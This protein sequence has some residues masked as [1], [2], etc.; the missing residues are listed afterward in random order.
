MNYRNQND[1]T[2]VLLTLAGEKEAFEALVVR[3]QNAVIAAAASVTHNHF[4]AEDASQDAFVTAWMK[5]DT[6]SEPAKFLAWVC[7]IA[8]FSAKNTVRRYRPFA[9]IEDVEKYADVTDYEQ[10]PASLYAI[11]EEKEEL[12][13]TVL[14][15]PEK[16]RRV[17][18]LHYFEELSVAEIAER[19]QISVGTVKSQLHEGRKKLRKEL[20]AMNEKANDTLVERVIKKVD[21]IK[22][23]QIMSDKSGFAE[24]YAGVLAEVENLPECKDKYHALADVLARGWWWLPGKKNEELFAR[25]KEAALIGK[26]DEIMRFILTR[27][28]GEYSGQKQIEF[29]RDVQIPA[30][31]KAG[32]VGALAYEHYRLGEK[33]MEKKEYE[34]SRASLEKALELAPASDTVRSLAE[35]M[36]TVLGKMA[37]K[38]GSA[39]KK[40]YAVGNGADKIK[41]IDGVPRFW[42]R[43]GYGEGYL[44]SGGDTRS[45]L[46]E[47]AGSCDGYFF[48]D[49]AL[50]ECY[51]ATDGSTLTYLCDSERVETPAGVFDGCRVWESKIYHWWE[52]TL[53]LRVYYKEG[54]GIVKH[55]RRLDGIS[56]TVSLT[57]FEIKGGEG[58]IPLAVGNKWEYALDTDP[59]YLKTFECYEVKH[60]DGECAIIATYDESERFGYDE[61]SWLEMIECVRNDYCSYD[62]K[63]N[64]KIEDVYRQIE[65]AEKL[66]VTPMEKLHSRVA[67]K[68]ARRIL[69]TDPE[70]NPGTKVTGHWNFFVKSALHEK[71]GDYH[72]THDSRFSFEWK[73][74]NGN[75]AED[76]LLF[77][78]MYGILQDATK[79]LW[80]DTWVVGATPVIEY[81]LYNRMPIK[82]TMSVEDGGSVT[83]KAGTFENCLK[84]S[85]KI[86]G[87]DAGHSYRGG[88][89]EY[90]FAEGIGIVRTVNDYAGGMKAIY[91]LSSY[92]GVGKGYMPF[93]DGLVRFYE[94]IDLTDGYYGAVEYTYIRNDDGEINI[95]EDMTGIRNIPA[96]TTEYEFVE[97]EVIEERIWDEKKLPEARLRNSANN[98]HLMLHFLSRNSRSW[99]CAPRGVAWAKYRL[100]MI[101][102]MLTDESGEIAPAWLGIYAEMHFMA[103]CTTFGCKKPELKDEAY[104]YLE[105][106]FELAPKWFAIADGTLLDVGD[107]EIY[108]GIK[109]EKGDHGTLHLPD[110]TREHYGEAWWINVSSP[111]RYYNAMTA[112]KGWEWFNSARDDERY[113]EF[114]KRAR[115]MMEKYSDA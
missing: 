28:D 29:M 23:W 72:L 88:N 7:K 92:E 19:M 75:A 91:E 86:E 100:K 56:D 101:E 58:L 89:K 39:N 60:F 61:S 33:Y 66:A 51:T 55:E 87:M 32:F 46:F 71:N 43:D 10:D 4:M 81:S 68:V 110:G 48:K 62:E 12:H 93:E 41:I 106:A 57:S 82:T 108:G 40:T 18:T 45:M 37:E 74:G 90:Y 114:V 27:E 113:K 22:L 104:A 53:Y 103:A 63:D 3:H 80:S 25:I 73:Y 85:L 102:N 8:M 35:G 30:L 79:C 36:L 16:V 64:C 50:G 97:R 31:E 78:H 84:L 20:C 69:D 5:L 13:R 11:S 96:P 9:P 1:E 21:E 99:K 65:L 44:R 54:V 52:G 95:F 59:E 115:E 67:A 105:R 94:A 24:V 6:L 15:L 98:L 14:S 76:A 2:L 111:A 42:N 77:N 83:T 112:K 26:N 107:K 49:L 34:E 109:I 38:Y 70:F 17:I 47:I